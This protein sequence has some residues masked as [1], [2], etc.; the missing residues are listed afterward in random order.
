[1]KIAIS[2]KSGCGNS[3]VSRIVAQRLGYKLVNYTFHSTAQE[4]GVSFDEMCE[5]A[6]QD[7]KWDLHVDKRQ[8]EMAREGDTVLGSRLAVWM[9][10]DADFR[11][12]LDARLDVR[13]ERIQKREGGDLEQ[14][15]SRTTQR[16]QRDH[17]RYRRLYG[18]DN[19]NFRFVDLVVDTENMTPQ[20][21]AD[22]IIESAGAGPADA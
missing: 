8:V 10:E 15:R 7:D 4:I 14:I 22:L 21:I 19:N 16:D 18:I 2:G 12:Y 1:M 20:E 13:G 17:D 5:L 11:V 6:E 9:L 3:T